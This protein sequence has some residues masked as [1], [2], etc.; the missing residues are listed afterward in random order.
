MVGQCGQRADLEIISNLD[1][2]N[3]HL[4]MAFTR[5][6]DYINA[7][8]FSFQEPGSLKLMPNKA[9]T[10]IAEV[11]VRYKDNRKAG[12]L[13]VV[14]FAPG[15]GTGNTNTYKHNQIH[16]PFFYEYVN[17]KDGLVPRSKTTPTKT[18][19]EYFFPFFTVFRDEVYDDG[20]CLDE[21]TLYNKADKLPSVSRGAHL[22]MESR[23]LFEALMQGHDLV[24][25]P[26]PK[27]QY[28]VG[29]K[30]GTRLGDPHSIFYNNLNAPPKSIQVAGF[31]AIKDPNDPLIQVVGKNAQWSLWEINNLTQ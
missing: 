23:H 6:Q 18:I 13:Y 8:G 3:K 16:I 27:I 2:A 11:E 10:A 15:D 29:Q 19:E 12:M 1:I 9:Y 26:K 21:L 4:G 14:A 30:N 17:K 5:Y 24:D 31:L 7:D 25:P 22:G 20:V 28:T